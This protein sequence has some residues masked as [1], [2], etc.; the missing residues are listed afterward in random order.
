MTISPPPSH[1]SNSTR[2]GYLTLATSTEANRAIADL[3]GKFCFDR[4]VTVQLHRSQSAQGTPGASIMAYNDTPS[5]KAAL[6]LLPASERKVKVK[7]EQHTHLHG[8]SST[9]DSITKIKEE[10][11]NSDSKDDL[12]VVKERK[13][14]KS[15][16]ASSGGDGGIRVKT[17]DNSDKDGTGGVIVVGE[18]RYDGRSAK[19]KRKKTDKTPSEKRENKR[20]K[21]D[22]AV[23]WEYSGIE[24]ASQESAHQLQSGDVLPKIRARVEKKSS[25]QERHNTTQ[26]TKL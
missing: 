4:H 24:A 12:V 20:K 14:S 18:E 26:C 10:S 11:M 13:V 16:R 21:E 5:V 6:D 8:D 22:A 23:E 15:G 25:K 19:K 2:N 17:N 1:H 7:Q 3:N 9:H